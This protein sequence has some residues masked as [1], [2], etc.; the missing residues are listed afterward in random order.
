M[1][2]IIS[3]PNHPKLADLIGMTEARAWG[4]TVA[5][6]MALYR[7]GNLDWNDIH[8]ICI[9]CGPEGSGKYTLAKAVAATCR[10]PLVT[11]GMPSVQAAE[12][13]IIR[14]TLSELGAAFELALKNAPC[15]LFMGRVDDI[16]LRSVPQHTP[17]FHGHGAA[18]LHV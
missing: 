3:H 13:S 16:L 18:Y 15:V 5:R 8:S 2:P 4:E 10:L 9:L 12:Q 7:S 17:I 14:A 6:G 1:A 11:V